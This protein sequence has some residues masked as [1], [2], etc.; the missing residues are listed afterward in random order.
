M[1]SAYQKVINRRENPSIFWKKSEG[2][3]GYFVYICLTSISSSS[4]R[5]IS[6]VLVFHLLFLFDLILC[7]MFL[8]H[9]LCCIELW[10]LRVGLWALHSA[11]PVFKS[12]PVLCV[13]SMGLW[14]GGGGRPDVG[15]M[16]G[17]EII[18]IRSCRETKELKW[19]GWAGRGD[20]AMSCTSVIFLVRLELSQGFNWNPDFK[21]TLGPSN[22]P[23]SQLHPC[24]NSPGWIHSCPK[25]I[26]TDR[27]HYNIREHHH[28]WPQLKLTLS[29]FAQDV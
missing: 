18:N 27:D 19:K 29:I 13:F 21:E 24:T 12:R 7:W 15:V 14:E 22:S 25:H 16:S 4:S 5:C 6:S 9:S 23:P 3:R 2:R 1:E 28:V 11:S 8:R 10:N 26:H 20:L 17:G